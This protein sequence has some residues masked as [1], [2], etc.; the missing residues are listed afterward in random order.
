MARVPVRVS[1]LAVTSA[2]V[3]AGACSDPVDD[4]SS[5]R[6]APVP[7]FKSVEPTDATYD[8]DYVIPA[9]TGERMD[10][11]EEVEIVPAELNVKV[12]EN[13]RV[14]NEDVRGAMVGIFWVPAKS[15]V[16]ME[17]NS[18]GT[19]SGECDVHPSGE[20]TITVTDV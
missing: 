17:F 19:L 12:G 18:A 15:T 14:V 7:E 1:F 8:Y 9:G 13:I 2:V 11:G 20:F 3:L 16:A 10:A 4:T 5:D 6:I